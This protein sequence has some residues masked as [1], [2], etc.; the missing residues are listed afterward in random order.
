[1]FPQVDAVPVGLTQGHWAQRP[2][3]RSIPPCGRR[4]PGGRVVAQSAG[5]DPGEKVNALSAQALAE[6]GVDIASE[7][8]KSID[9]GLL[10]T[11]DVVVTLSREAK[12]DV[13][14][15]RHVRRYMRCPSAAI[16]S[17]L[18]SMSRPARCCRA[19][20]VGIATGPV[21]SQRASGGIEG[22]RRR[23]TVSPGR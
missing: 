17:E 1:M 13:P 16:L 22:P 23:K 2:S 10:R 3:T 14:D 12:V 9:P 7:V 20:V 11:V 8:P 19:L 5:I 6:V 18:M 15:G 21:F 4:W